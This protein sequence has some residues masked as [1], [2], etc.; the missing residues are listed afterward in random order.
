MRSLC[1]SFLLATLCFGQALPDRDELVKKFLEPATSKQAGM[2][3]IKHFQ[4]GGLR[5]I[6]RNLNKVPLSDRLQYGEMLRHMDLMRFRNDLNANVETAPDATTRA[7]ALMLLSTIGR[8]LDPSV[9]NPYVGDETVDMR[10]RLAAMSGLVKVQKIDQYNRF[11][12]V[13]E[14]AVVD[15]S[16]GQNDLLF[17]DISKKNLGFYLYTRTQLDETKVPHGAILAAITMAENDS[18]D[19]YEAILKLRKKKYIPLLID[20]AIKVGGVQLLEAMAK[21]KKAKKFK[22]QINAALPAAQMVTAYRSKFMDHSDPKQTPIG[23]LLPLKGQG[24]SNAP[25][26][27]AGYAIAKVSANGHISVLGHQ[28]PFGSSDNLKEIL[29]G[30]TLPAY[31]NWEAVESY[32][33]IVAP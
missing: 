2:D 31:L 6:I 30:T 21:N 18:V 25:G 22:A 13:A 20:R 28:A 10:V 3:L 32:A 23:P 7:L 26:Y 1:I 17:A 27:R 5:T 12:E 4:M 11:Y 9:F 29:T 14:T 19:I 15:P 33:L 24:T 16:T 8:N